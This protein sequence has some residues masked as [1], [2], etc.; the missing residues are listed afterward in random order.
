MKIVRYGEPGEEKP[1]LIDLNGVLRSLTPV[2]SDW[3]VDYLSPESLTVLNAIQPEKLPQVA[4][5][6]RFGYPIAN[7]RQIVAIGLNYADHAKEA[8]MAEPSQP[9]LFHKAISSL[10]GPNDDVV[11]PTGSSKTDWE[12]ELGVIIG[13]IARSVSAADAGKY[14]A[15]YC[16]AMDVSEREWQFDRGGLLNKGK[17]ADTFTPVGPWMSTADAVPDPQALRIWLKVNDISRQNGNTREMIFNVATLIEHISQYQTLMPGELILTG[18]PAGV[19]FGMKPQRYLSAGDVMEC[20]IDGL[21][22]QRHK[23]VAQPST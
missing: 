16:L 18:T 20:G 9:L 7:F 5:Q 1:G 11:I 21:G 23:L 22:E 17:S 3:T 10:C 2:I 12:V 14:I 13:R 6:P 15:G 19:G 8:G 4:G